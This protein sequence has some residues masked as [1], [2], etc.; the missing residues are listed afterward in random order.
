MFAAKLPLAF[1]FTVTAVLADDYVHCETSDASPPVSSC[2]HIA[3]GFAQGAD[4][5]CAQPYG[6]GCR[7]VVSNNLGC[8]FVLCMQDGTSPQ[9]SDPASAAKFTKALIDQCAKDGKVGGYY[10]QDLGDGR[11][12]NYEFTK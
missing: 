3:D 8:S 12:L 10:H 11:Y 1:A 7:T 4:P 2:Q 6:S 5:D 9:C